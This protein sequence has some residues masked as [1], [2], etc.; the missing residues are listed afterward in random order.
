LDDDRLSAVAV[1]VLVYLLSKPDNWN[2]RADDL[3][4]RFGIGRDKVYKTL[5]ELIGYGYLE[6][7]IIRES[8]RVKESV[9]SVIELPLTDLPFPEIQE[10]V[11]S[12]P[13]PLPDLPFPDLPYTVNTDYK[14][15]MS[16]ASNERETNKQTAGD[17]ETQTLDNQV[18]SLSNDIA[19]NPISN[20]SQFDD[21]G[22]P[23]SDEDSGDELV[24]DTGRVCRAWYA[25]TA[26]AVNQVAMEVLLELTNMHGVDLVLQAI[27]QIDPSRRVSHPRYL[28]PI[29]TTIKQTA[30]PV[31][32]AE[33]IKAYK[34]PLTNNLPAYT[35]TK[36]D[37]EIFERIASITTPSGLAKFIQTTKRQ[38]WW[39]NNVVSLKY[40]SQHITGENNG[41][42]N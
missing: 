15:V 10:V 42:A 35:P 14:Q 21:W 24:T 31:H 33:Y 41:Y 12:T 8:G 26:V 13:P 3:Q 20:S 28:V 2:A 1:A 17:C 7:E 22:I 30:T 36:W 34:S 4:K 11:T 18:V 40:I 16:L 6:R 29:I 25:K 9:Y 38:E 39:Q 5:D 32:L 27:E 37:L 19:L 23:Q